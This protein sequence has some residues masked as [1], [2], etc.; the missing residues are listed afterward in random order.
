MAA[1]PF[2]DLAL[3]DD[4]LI[5]AFPAAQAL[6]SEPRPNCIL[7][8]SL[9]IIRLTPGGLW[10]P[11]F[12][13]ATDWHTMRGVA[14][15]SLT[16]KAT[17]KYSQEVIRPI[18][19]S[20][21]DFDGRLHVDRRSLRNKELLSVAFDEATGFS[22]NLGRAKEVSSALI[23]MLLCD[24]LLAFLQEDPSVPIRPVQIVCHTQPPAGKME[25]YYTAAITEHRS[26]IMGFCTAWT[27]HEKTKAAAEAV[28]RK[29]VMTQ[30]MV[31]AGKDRRAVLESLVNAAKVIGEESE[32]KSVEAN[33]Y[34]ASLA[35]AAMMM[36]SMHLESATC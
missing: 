9:L 33:F 5:G 25:P 4:F 1:N 27:N 11:F 7:Q 28:K 2:S 20:V 19:Q 34:N 8:K 35:L 36:V 21:I 10:S 31:V 26:T 32:L 24:R 18:Y 6:S 16:G 17:L 30:E 29:T 23:N 15:G 14:E 13:N 22:K 3:N 12:S